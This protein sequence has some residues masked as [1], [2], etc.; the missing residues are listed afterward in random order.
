MTFSLPFLS[1]YS[2]SFFSSWGPNMK[3]SSAI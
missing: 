1:P 3:P 2:F